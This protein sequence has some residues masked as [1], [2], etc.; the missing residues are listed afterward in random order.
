MNTY[1]PLEYLFPEHLLKASPSLA[2]GANE[3][4]ENRCVELLFTQPGK[5]YLFFFF[6]KERF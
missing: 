5:T 2:L 6:E 4:K 1:E 3:T